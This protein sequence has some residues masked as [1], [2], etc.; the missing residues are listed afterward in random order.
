MLVQCYK[1][2]TLIIFFVVAC[3]W[4][5]PNHNKAPEECSRVN[6]FICNP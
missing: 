1:K 5:K 2:V 3:F 4:K 6:G